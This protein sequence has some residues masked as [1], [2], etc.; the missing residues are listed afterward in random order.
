MS[1]LQQLMVALRLLWRDWRAGEVTLLAAAIVIAVG[2]LT[3]VSFFTDRVQLALMQQSNQLLG[4]DLSIVSDRPFAAEFAATA[5][6]RGL[7]VTRALRFPSMASAGGESLLTDIKAVAPNYPLR[8]EVRL[9][10]ALFGAE[11]IAREIPAPGTAWV[12]DRLFT[13]LN[14]KPG[15]TVA[16][17][18]AR[19]RIAALVAQEPDSVIGFINSAPRVLMNEADIESSGLL[20]AGSRVRYRLYVAGE[21][22]AV[23]AYRAWAQTHIG[24]GQTIEGIRD[25]RPEIR[26]ALERAERFLG[27]AALV[28]V[29]LSAVAIALAARRFL[30][31]HLD[32]CAVMRCLGARQAIVVR[33]YLLHFIALGAVAGVAGCLIGYAAQF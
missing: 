27:L 28:S 32:G 4:A 11:R 2:S 18:R 31:R 15:D 19:L 13:R 29:I 25:A 16:V 24:A 12:D 17:G 10:D 33:L 8:G 3:T 20:Q 6:T 14:V 9:A 23:D 1:A 22:T 30:R 7:A 21:T 26:S 5:Q